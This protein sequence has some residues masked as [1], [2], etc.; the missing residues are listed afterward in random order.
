MQTSWWFFFFYQR[1]LIVPWEHTFLKSVAP[2][3][4]K[5]LTLAVLVLLYIRLTL[6][7]LDRT[8]SLFSVV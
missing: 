2:L 8:H 3:R 7:V 4:V 1:L 6:A 5:P